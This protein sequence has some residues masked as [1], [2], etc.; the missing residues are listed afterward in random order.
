MQEATVGLE[1]YRE[2][3]HLCSSSL[4]WKHHLLLCWLLLI[5]FCTKEVSVLFCSQNLALKYCVFIELRVGKRARW[6]KICLTHVYHERHC[7]QWRQVWL[8]WLWALWATRLQGHFCH[9]HG[10]G[11]SWLGTPCTCLP[12]HNSSP[13]G[14]QHVR[15]L[16]GGLQSHW[17]RN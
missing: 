17:C 12:G 16:T 11:L 15:A 13:L 1:K 9:Q 3:K 14:R 8:G 4:K 2:K 5:F 10:H 7:H 6:V